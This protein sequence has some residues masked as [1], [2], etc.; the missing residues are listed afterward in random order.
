[1]GAVTCAMPVDARQASLLRRAAHRSVYAADR[2]GVTNVLHA[3]YEMEDS[4]LGETKDAVGNPK[5]FSALVEL[6]L[7][8]TAV[9]AMR[10]SKLSDELADELVDNVSAMHCGFK[11]DEPTLDAVQRAI[12]ACKVATELGAAHDQCMSVFKGTVLDG[13]VKLCRHEF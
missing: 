8:A 1:M 7:L 13:R 10:D 6:A 5:A 9:S 12:D 3:L 4:P 2:T 11:L